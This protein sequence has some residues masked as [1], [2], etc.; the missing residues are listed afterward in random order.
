LRLNSNTERDDGVIKELSTEPLIP[1]PTAPFCPK[2]TIGR[3]IISDSSI[4]DSAS[5]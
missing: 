3:P 1:M 5:I 2:S 4:S